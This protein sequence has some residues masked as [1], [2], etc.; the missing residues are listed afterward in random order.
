MSHELALFKTDAIVVP[1][2]TTAEHAVELKI[3]Q[4]YSITLAPQA[5]VTFAQAP[6]ARRTVDA[7]QAGLLRFDVPRTA[8]YRVSADGP[9]WLDVVA[10][11]RE[12]Q[13]TAF[14]GHAH[15]TLIH[16][17]VDL[18]LPAG[19]HLVLQLS[20]S[21]REVVRIAITPAPPAAPAG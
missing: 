10:G 14:N 13:S 17:S 21:T 2:G 12:I 16:K 20:K 8:H 19:V 6:G 3:E 11:D 4:L 9:V 5:A 1:A 15:C 7:L 18:E